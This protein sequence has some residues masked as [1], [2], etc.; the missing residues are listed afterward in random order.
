MDGCDWTAYG[1]EPGKRYYVALV[2]LAMGDLNAL[3]FGACTHLVVAL[4][5]GASNPSE[6]LH[7]DSD[8]PTVLSV[9]VSCR[10]TSEPFSLRALC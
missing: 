7:L 10:A 3:E 5:S 6:I 9:G 1:A 4:R 8:L 2:V